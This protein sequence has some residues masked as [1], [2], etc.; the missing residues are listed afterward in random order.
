MV[1]WLV[2]SQDV[3]N[4]GKWGLHQLSEFSVDSDSWALKEFPHA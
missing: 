4:R 2:L 3:Q 1:V